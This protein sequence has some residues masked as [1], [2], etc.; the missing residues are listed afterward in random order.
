MKIQVSISLGELVDKIT[1]LRIKSKKITDTTKLAYVHDELKNLEQTLSELSLDSST[2]SG[3]LEDLEKVNFELWEIEDKIREKERVKLFD[4][5]FIDLARKVY[6][7]ND[8]RFLIKNNC[9]QTFGSRFK[10][11][12]SYEKYD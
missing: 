6:L 8:Q 10:E 9:N 7:T 5:E 1:I 2:M 3:F 4:E 12:K 11:V